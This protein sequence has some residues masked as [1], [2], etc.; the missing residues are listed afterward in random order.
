MPRTPSDGGTTTTYGEAET[1]ATGTTPAVLA[2]S[3]APV[4]AITSMWPSAGARATW[5][6]PILPLAP[7]RLSTTTDCFHVLESGVD[8][9]RASVSAPPAGGNGT[10]T[11]TVREGN[12]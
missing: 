4:A 6:T 12:V 10:T 9:M 3:I 5:P 7:G 1:R 2:A 11:V 8:R